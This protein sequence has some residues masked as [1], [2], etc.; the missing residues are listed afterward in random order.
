MFEPVTA[1]GIAVTTAIVWPLLTS[2]GRDDDDDYTPDE[3]YDGVDRE[4]D[5]SSSTTGSSSRS[6]SGGERQTTLDEF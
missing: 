1:V 3:S 2:T 6:G 4:I 5:Y